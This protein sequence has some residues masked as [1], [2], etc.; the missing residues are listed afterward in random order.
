MNFQPPV[1]VTYERIVQFVIASGLAKDEPEETDLRLVREL[2]LTP[3][4]ACLARDRVYG[5]LVRASTGN[6]ANCPD[7]N[8]DP[9]AYM[10]YQLAMEDASLVQALY[11]ED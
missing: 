7:R 3:D 2:G 8:K 9:L 5:G 10:S 11:P 6:S 1:G 4:D